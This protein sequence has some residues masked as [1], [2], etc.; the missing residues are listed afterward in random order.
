[1]NPGK[2]KEIA[3]LV[4]SDGQPKGVTHKKGRLRDELRRRVGEQ[5]AGFGLEITVLDGQRLGVLGS[6]KPNQRGSFISALR[7]VEDNVRFD[8]VVSYSELFPS[9]S[10]EE[11]QKALTDALFSVFVD[12]RTGLVNEAAGHGFYELLYA[13]QQ[14]IPS[15]IRHSDLEEALYNF[16]VVRSEHDY[17]FNA[18]DAKNPDLLPGVAGRHLFP[19]S[20]ISISAGSLSGLVNA[21]NNYGKAGSND[22]IV[23]ECLDRVLD[24]MD[25]FRIS[26]R[27]LPSRR[28]VFRKGDRDYDSNRGRSLREDEAKAVVETLAEYVQARIP[29]VERNIELGVRE[30]VSW[31]DVVG[32]LRNPVLYEALG[33][34][35]PPDSPLVRSLV[36]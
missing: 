6:L 21:L 16:P 27:I 24:E 20:E 7:R 17:F 19:E 28:A 34:V 18:I 32:M 1:M 3:T 11:M 25:S 10:H 36:Y 2:K 23:G 33:K 9:Y 12:E 29:D 5:L 4:V 13:A 35:H 14:R 22:N 8:F 31:L 30:E 15:V 26:R